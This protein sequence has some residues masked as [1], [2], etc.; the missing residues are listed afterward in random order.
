MSVAA[1]S[2]RTRSRGC[3]R[4]ARRAEQ[5]MRRQDLILDRETGLLV[6]EQ[7]RDQ[8]QIE[9]LARLDGAVDQSGDQRL[10]Q[11]AKIDPRHLHPGEPRHADA[12]CAADRASRRR[13]VCISRR[14]GR[15]RGRGELRRDIAVEHRRADMIEPALE[16]GPDLAADIGPAFAERKI[17]AEI[18]SGLRDRSCIRTAQSGWGFRPAHR[19]N[20]RE[21]TAAIG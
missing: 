2:A 10:P 15:Q 19:A 4:R 3:R 1:A 18:G 7:L 8:R 6:A 16:I 5:L 21:R 12:V 13:T 20:A 11:R 9:P 14:I 17:L